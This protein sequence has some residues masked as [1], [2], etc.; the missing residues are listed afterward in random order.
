PKPSERWTRAAGRPTRQALWKRSQAYLV[1]RGGHLKSQGVMRTNEIVLVA[2]GIKGG[3]EIEDVLPL[4][5]HEKL[6]DK[7]AVKPL[8]FAHGLRVVR[9][10][11]TYRDPQAH[12]R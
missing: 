9:S 7:R 6:S 3:L 8:I 12:V 11:V 1:A 4:P 5:S 10:A 2:E